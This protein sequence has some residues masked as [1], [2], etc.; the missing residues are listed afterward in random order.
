MDLSLLTSIC[1]ELGLKNI[2]VRY[3]GQFMLWLEN[4]SEKPILVRILKKVIWLPLKVFFK[5]IPVK[6]K[7][8]SPYIIITAQK[9]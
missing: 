2:A 3:D 6:S 7:Y 9:S 1:S 4:E 8:F 5:I